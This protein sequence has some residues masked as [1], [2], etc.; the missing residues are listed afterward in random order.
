MLREVSL[1]KLKLG[2][3][4][5]WGLE[6]RTLQMLRIHCVEEGPELISGCRRDLH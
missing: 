2:K 4:H 3:P 1:Q 6:P 5:V